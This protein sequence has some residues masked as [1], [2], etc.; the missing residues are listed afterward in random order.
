MPLGC[1]L[2]ASWVPPIALYLFGAHVLA[3]VVTGP[4]PYV[5]R[6]V[7][8]AQALPPPSLPLPHL[9]SYMSYLADVFMSYLAD[10]FVP[11]SPGR[12][13]ILR[14]HFLTPV[15]CPQCHRASFVNRP[16]SP[17]L[18]CIN[19]NN[20]L[21]VTGC[22]IFKQICNPRGLK[23]CGS[24]T[25]AS[26]LVPK[27]DLKS[28]IRMQTLHAVLLGGSWDSLRQLVLDDD[29]N[30]HPENT[31]DIMELIMDFVI[32]NDMPPLSET[33]KDSTCEPVHT[34]TWR[35]CSPAV[36]SESKV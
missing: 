30:N 23:A 27:R 21:K 1:L 20:I 28:M 24:S 15:P 29:D 11:G 4:T 34:T 13:R 10:V 32:N 25:L 14:H 18:D 2:G 8:F 31:G 7:T 9:C 35:R 22:V 12:D 3:L 36:I 5:T 33:H 6:N 17:C 16:F 26:F 19:N